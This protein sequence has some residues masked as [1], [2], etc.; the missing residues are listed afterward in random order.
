MLNADFQRCNVLFTPTLTH[1]S[2][3]MVIWCTLMGEGVI[4]YVW[5]S[6]LAI[7]FGGEWPQKGAKNVSKNWQKKFYFQTYTK[8]GLLSRS[9]PIFSIKCVNVQIYLCNP[10]SIFFL[11]LIFQVRGCRRRESDLAFAEIFPSRQK[12]STLQH[13]KTLKCS[14]V[15]IYYVA[16]FVAHLLGY[17]RQLPY[18]EDL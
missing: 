18:N 7:I 14:N 3:S 12:S 1:E 2:S 9:Y 11:S 15:P 8:W 17:T 5:R 10:N 16:F 13:C 6:R 4:N